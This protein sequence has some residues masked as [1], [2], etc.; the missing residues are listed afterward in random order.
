VKGW[1]Q[2]LRAWMD[3]KVGL[4]RSPISPSTHRRG[5]FYLLPALSG[6][7]LIL[8]Q[9]PVSLFWF[10]YF[11]LI[12]LL[13]AMEKEKTHHHFMTGFVA[14][15][16]SFFG[17]IYWVIIAMNRYGGI[18]L[19]TS[20]IILL[21]LVLYV[22]L[23]T[24]CFTASVTWLDKRLSVPT[25]LSAPF[26]W[27]L[28]EYVRGIALTGFPWSLLAHSQYNF[29]TFI[30]VVSV[31][32]TYFISFLIVAVNCI[33]YCLLRKRR[34]S[35]VYVTVIL[36]L[37]AASI[38]YGVKEVRIRDRETL[39]AGIIQGNI[40]QDVKWDTAFKIKTMKTYFTQ[41]LEAGYGL[42][43]IIWPETAMPFIF[44]EEP[45]AMRFVRTLPAITGSDLIFGT[46]SRDKANRFYNSAYGVTK[47]GH[48]LVYDKVHLV[49]F[50]EYTPL[51]S[52][53][54]FLE[55]LTAVGGGFSPGET[56][57]PMSLDKGR[58]GLLI[59]YEGIFPS[60]TNDTVRRGAQVLANLTNDA[61][62]D[63]TSAPYQHFAFYIFRAIETHRYVLRSAN[64]GISAIIDSRGRVKEA[65]PI[66]V[67][68]VLTGA[69]ALNDEKTP[70]VRF[71]D[72]FVLLAAIFLA[73][74]CGAGYLRRARSRSE[75]TLPS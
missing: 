25:Y 9:P 72:W 69:F 6:I 20:F 47:T 4:P 36:I 10:A 3:E 62:Y 73:G 42:D 65:T 30:Q 26:L 5:T 22:S 45:E 38:V 52:Y 27:V 23:Y 46:V 12:P 13:V 71:G 67:S 28:L 37:F 48:I 55:K 34:I 1:M 18:D 49:P 32:G 70:Y 19:F 57:N 68:R 14:G 53:F 64:T 58:V 44:N 31:T 17:L 24:G 33:L 16:V 11:A 15:L 39:R 51:I 7:L 74:M 54:P 59:C 2:W 8:A 60:I 63:R 43:L 41:S 21:L 35:G 61:W 40:T 75:K 50:G 66:F 29:L 56:H